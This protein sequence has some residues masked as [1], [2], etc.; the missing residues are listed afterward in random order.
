MTQPQFARD[1]DGEDWVDF[2]DNPIRKM[3]DTPPSTRFE[4]SLLDKTE[5]M[6][7]PATI[8]EMDCRFRFNERFS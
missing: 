3:F 2:R 4:K 1:D 8:H 7:N 6:P 5:N